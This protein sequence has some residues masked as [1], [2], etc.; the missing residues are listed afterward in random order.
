MFMQWKVSVEYIEGSWGFLVVQKSHLCTAA[1][2]R[3]R[4]V[5]GVGEK[6]LVVRSWVIPNRHLHHPYNIAPLLELVSMWEC[7]IIRYVWCSYTSAFQRD[8]L[9]WSLSCFLAS[10]WVSCQM[11]SPN[12]QNTL[13]GE[14]VGSSHQSL[15]VSL[16][17]VRWNDVLQ[18]DI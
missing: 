5:S 2:L 13:G 12:H 14:S 10:M 6:P 18:Y 7:L 8:L 1:E 4:T 11:E 3:E 15:Q 9:F 16:S 17:L